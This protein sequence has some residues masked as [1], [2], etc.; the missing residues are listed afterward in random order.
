MKRRVIVEIRPHGRILPAPS[1]LISQMP[2]AA[3][4]VRHAR[5]GSLLTRPVIVQTDHLKTLV[6][7]SPRPLNEAHVG[8]YQGVNGREPSVR[9]GETL[10]IVRESGSGKT[11]HGTGDHL[12]LIAF[13]RG[14][15]GSKGRQFQDHNQRQMPTLR[16]AMP[17]C[18]RNPFGQPVAAA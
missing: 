18:F 16:S 10:G 17:M 6:P 12:R 13:R 11:T 5:P 15:S 1:T 2:A 3:E 4:V 9:A 14:G 7:D 8:A